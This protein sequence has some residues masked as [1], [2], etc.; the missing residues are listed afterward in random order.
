MKKI[1]FA[2]YKKHIFLVLFLTIALI[3][4]IKKIIYLSSEPISDKDC[5]PDFSRTPSTPA[6]ISIKQPDYKNLPLQQRGG[7]INDAS[8]LNPT[9]IE[10]IV[11]VKSEEDIQRAL[12]VA[13]ENNLKVSIAGARHSMGGQAFVDN[14]LVLDITRLNRMTLD[15]EN[16]TLTVGSGATWK[17][18]QAFLHPQGFA[19]KAMQSIDILT[20]GGTLGA[21]AHGIDHKTGAIASTIKSLRVIMAD[22][23][24][25]RVSRSE[26]PELFRTIIGG[27]GL[28]GVIVDAEIEVTENRMYTRQ[29]EVINY[30]DFPRIFSEINADDHYKLLYAHLSPVP[31]S[32]MQEMILYTYKESSDTEK[33]IPLLQEQTH[34]KLTRFIFNYAKHGLGGQQLKWWVEK[35]FLPKYVGCNLSRNEAMREPE[36]CL[37]SR[38]QAMSGSQKFINNNLR[39]DTDV[40]QEYFIPR[41]TFVPFV[42]GMR[43]ILK[44]NKATVMN[45]SVRVVNKEDI[46]LNYAKQDMFSIVLYLNQGVSENENAKI[47]RINQQ[48]IDLATQLDGTFYLTYQLH[49]S[50]EQ[51]LETYPE[52]TQFFALKKKYDPNLMFRNKFFEKY[53]L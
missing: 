27:Y 5:G 25:Q 53:S 51:L 6:A 44:E 14:G 34:V 21:N 24:I 31:S 38:N 22:G 10:G 28:F 12:R 45:A 37:I 4:L 52:V 48:L 30:K 17:D 13:N 7:T 36:A 26:N 3:G 15:K 23:S 33:P 19:V 39:N 8:C 43:E 1:I 41:D 18:V 32:F 9:M 50:K 16:K 35:T 46:A 11:K 42:D 40:F 29:Q 49:Y 2:K 47:A 20:V